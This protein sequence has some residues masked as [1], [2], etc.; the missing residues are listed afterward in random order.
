MNWFWINIPLM[1]VFF[2]AMT[3]ISLWLVLK[4]PDGP[5]V[6]P[7]QPGQAQPGQAQPNSLA[8]RYGATRAGSAPLRQIELAA[9]SDDAEVARPQLA[10]A[11]R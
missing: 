5:Q 9:V 4:Y 11:R 10:E 8:A 2:L 6:A 7:A 3:G 1:A